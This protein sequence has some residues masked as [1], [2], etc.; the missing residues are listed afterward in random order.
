VPAALLG[1]ASSVEWLLSYCGSP[2]GV[3]AAGAAAGAFGPRAV[4]VVGGCLAALTALVLLVPG[5]GEHGGLQV[6]D[7]SQGTR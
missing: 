6:S 1:R 3:V 2:V 7:S 4:L 5:V